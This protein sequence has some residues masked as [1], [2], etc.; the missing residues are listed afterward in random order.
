MIIRCIRCDKD[1]ESDHMSTHVCPACQFVFGKGGKDEGKLVVVPSSESVRWKKEPHRLHEGKTTRCAHHPDVDAVGKCACCDK[2]LCYACSVETSQGCHCEL[3]ASAD[4]AGGQAAGAEDPFE[5]PTVSTPSGTEIPA[6]AAR[7][8]TAGQAL[9]AWEHR[10]HTCRRR[11]LFATWRRSL[12]SPS[13]FFLEARTSTHWFSPLAYGVWWILIA[14]VGV[15]VWKLGLRAYP[16]ARMFFGREAVDISFQLSL[17]PTFVKT[18]VAVGLCPLAAF[19]FL[20][21]VCALFH[22]SI[23]ALAR[24]H[25]GFK[26]TLRVVCYSMGVGAFYFLPTVGGLIAAIWQLVI[27]TIG[28]KHSHRIPLAVAAAAALVPWAL[29]A[30]CGLALTSWAVAGSGLDAGHVFD[31][32]LRLLKG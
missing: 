13:R 31:G 30:A 15:I 27:I 11:A 8:K 7:D 25:S 16:A 18:G 23:F 14:L 5:S 6:Y 10:R 24:A 3:C 28:F 2:P 17:S 9:V 20:T 12:L 26:M 21:A 29:L 22:L 4:A 19:V 32:L 1:F